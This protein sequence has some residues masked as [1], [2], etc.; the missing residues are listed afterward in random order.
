[1]L[2]S[3]AERGRL[4]VSQNR[5]DAANQLVSE[6]VRD[7]GVKEPQKAFI[8]TQTRAEAK[9]INKL[10]Q[11]ARRFEAATSSK[12]VVIQN[13]VYHVGDRVM[14][15]KKI[16]KKGI[17]NGYQGKVT[18]I[19]AIK[20]TVTF[21]LDRKPTEQK[22]ARGHT[23]SVAVAIKELSSDH[24]TLGYAATTHKL[25]GQSIER[26]YCL[27]GG[28]MTNKELTYVQLTRGEIATKLF[29]D[30]DHA[31][32]KLADIA[33]AMK[34]SGRKDLAHDQ[35]DTNRLRLQIQPDTKES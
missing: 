32:K 29:I 10:C 1:M 18:A 7:G 26:A 21:M 16:L 14:F 13:Q 5:A 12:S 34:Q 15:H 3:Y 17:E 23:Q 31:G 11:T 2:E 19:D 9:Q 4:T 28:G 6:W 33:D 8:L 27:L 24:L 25:Q 35:T 30:R 20:R 22:S